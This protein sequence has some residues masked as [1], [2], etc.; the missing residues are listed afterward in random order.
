MSTF[1]TL[2]T[3][4]SGLLASQRAMDT[5]GQNV[6]NANTPGYSRQRV[7]LSAV[8]APPSASFH[9]GSATPLG[10]VRV[11]AVTRIRDAYLEATRA[12]AGSRQQALAAQDDTLTTTQ[13]LFSEPGTN[14]MQS[15]LD[16]FYSSWHDLSLNPT[17]DASGSVVLQRAQGLVDQVHTVSSGIAAEWATARSRLEQVVAETNQAAGDLASLNSQILEGVGAGRP[18]NELLDQRDILVRKLADL[19]GGYAVRAPDSTI[20]LA[21][22]GVTIVAAGTAQQLTLTGATDLQAA[23]GSPPTISWGSM[24]VPVESGAAAGYLAALR[25]DL[26]SLSTAVDDV[27]NALRDAVNSVHATGF[28]LGGAAGGPFFSGTGAHDLAVVP[29]DPAQLAISSASGTVDG[30]VALKIGDLASDVNASAALG[31]AA[32]P[33]SRWR[34][35]TTALGT[36]L[37]SLKAAVAAQD[38]VVTAADD[39]V[40]S[41]SGVNL[42]EEMTGMMLFQRAYQASARVITTIDEMMDT[43]INRTGTVGR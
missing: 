26:P 18:V 1:S 7:L 41:D 22:N 37:Q 19:V 15:S 35:V 10:G 34:S 43:L 30:G 25:T 14:G 24:A 4:V 20:S 38:S 5:A 29:T 17:N 23:A 9:T 13:L 8:G 42:D 6:V 33:S 32:G 21:V 31:G 27:A 12:A 16:A 2:N 39:A 28:T 3:A 36:Q 11:D 40:N